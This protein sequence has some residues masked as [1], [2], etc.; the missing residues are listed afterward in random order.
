MQSVV[1]TAVEPF[2]QLSVGDG[3]M[4]ADGG[5]VT[6]VEDP[7]VAVEGEGVCEGVAWGMALTARAEA[8]RR[9]R[10]RNIVST[11]DQQLYVL[12]YTKED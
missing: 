10:D 3:V 5:E 9:T 11:L 6:V 2:E 12:S 7:G 8:S 1:Y 4:V